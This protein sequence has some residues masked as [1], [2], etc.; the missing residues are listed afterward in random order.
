MGIA[1]CSSRAFSTGTVAS[2]VQPTTSV[3]A[4]I[5]GSSG[6]VGGTFTSLWHGAVAFGVTGVAGT[7]AGSRRKRAA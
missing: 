2:S 7:V 3:S 1:P 6:L 5:L 4:V